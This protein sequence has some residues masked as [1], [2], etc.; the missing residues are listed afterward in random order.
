MYLAR[1]FRLGRL[2]IFGAPVYI[3]ASA[4]VAAALLGL[5]ALNSPVF[6]LL[7][8]CSYLGIIFVHETGHAFVASHLGLDVLN[9]RIGW[10]HGIC[11]Y[12]D[13]GSEWETVLVA[14]GGVLAQLL[15][16]ALVF[17]VAA[18]DLFKSQ[19]YFGPIIVFLG[20]IN[21]MVAAINLAPSR[22]LDGAIAWRIV[23]LWLRQ[24]RARRMA[25]NAINE[26][27][28]KG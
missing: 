21:F 25:K 16:A 2:R 26:A 18:L 11:V 13:P 19:S 7:A 23:P 6:G 14:W 28:K 1:Y 12:E 5:S 15:I 22:G 9:I 3:Q 20:Y 8:I 10:F 24:N 4:L 27:R 17:G